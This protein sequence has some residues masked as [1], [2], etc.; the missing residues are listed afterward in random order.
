VIVGLVAGVALGASFTAEAGARIYNVCGT[1]GLPGYQAG[2]GYC[3]L[4]I[5]LP[6]NYIEVGAGDGSVAVYRATAGYL[7]APSASGTEY[8]GSGGVFRQYFHCYAGYPA[9]HNRH[10][11]AVLIYW[12]QAEDCI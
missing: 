8:W 9:E 2:H 10:S 5:S 7:G 3:N 11:Y 6:I 1:A 4:G 12:V